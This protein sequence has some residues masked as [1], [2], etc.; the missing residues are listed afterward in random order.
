MARFNYLTN[1]TEVSKQIM[2]EK[3]KTAK[4][5]VDAT[6]GNG[7]DLLYLMRQDVNNA[8]FYGF[9]IQELAI[10]NSHQ[11]ITESR[12]KNK[13]VQ[14]I[15]DSHANMMAYIHEPVDLFI[16]NLGYLPKGDH[17]VTTKADSTIQA[18]NQS[19]E[20]LANEGLIIIAVYHG[21]EEG[22]LEKLALESHLEGLNQKL[23]TVA[24]F[25]FIN[26]INHPPFLYIIEKS[27]V[28]I[29]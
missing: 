2:Q 29:D 7:N 8:R 27:K 28:I 25:E 9:D 19:L 1:A 12:E 13:R 23:F 10:E 20:L 14:L 22:K 24:K 4:V 21:H 5:V 26:Q 11:K 17:Q 3:M 18:V 6:L 16:Y 15:C